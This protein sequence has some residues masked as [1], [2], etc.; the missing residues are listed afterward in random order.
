MSNVATKLFVLKKEIPL[1][2]LLYFIC[3]YSY[4]KNTNN[5]QIIDRTEVDWR[6]DPECKKTFFENGKL[7]PKYK[8]VESVK[9]EKITYM[10][11]GLKIKGYLAM[12]RNKG[13]HPCI[14]WNRGGCREFSKLRPKTAVIFLG[15]QASWGY[16]VVGSQLRGNDGGEGKD[17]FGGNDIN[18]ILNLFPLLENLKNADT[19]KIGMYGWSRGSMMT[20][21]ILTKINRIKAVVVGGIVSD[22]QLNLKYRPTFE[23]NV[24]SQVIPNYYKNK[25]LELNKR[26]AIKFVHKIVKTTPILMM[27]GA[28]D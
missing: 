18:D 16:I 26:S 10:S 22:Q 13:K 28:S 17:Q 5:G 11:D 24:F 20:F 2:F 6:S 9:I 4:A 15:R 7:K 12:P 1:F 8:Y 23:K 19:N 21:L 25:E 27:H 14:I 3:F